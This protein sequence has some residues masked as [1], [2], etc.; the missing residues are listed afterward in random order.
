MRLAE[1]GSEKMDDKR[2]ANFLLGGA[3][4]A[5]TINGEAYEPNVYV[6]G[7]GADKSD[8]ELTDT[9][10]VEAIQEIN[11]KLYEQKAK[12]L[13]ID[14]EEHFVMVGSPR[15]LHALKREA[16]YRDWVR[17]AE[18][19]GRDNP[20][21]RGALA[22]IDGMILFR[23]SNCPVEADGGAGANVPTS[24]GIAFGREAFV[25]GLDENVAWNEDTFDYGNEL[26]VAYRFAFQPRRALEL[27]SV[28]VMAAAPVPTGLA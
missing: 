2:F 21:F 16:E 26:G 4:G 27:S 28:Q 6:V 18:V 15:A 9:L 12:P 1:W 23:H 17:E 7:G 11:L 10:T 3:A 19:R 8:V 13:R 20:F 24:T 5:Q 25:E 14:G 22:V